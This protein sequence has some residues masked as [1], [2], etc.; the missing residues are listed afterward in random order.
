MERL[1]PMVLEEGERKVRKAEGVKLV[2]PLLSARGSLLLTDRR[3]LFNGESMWGELAYEASLDNI[4]GCDVKKPSFWSRG[5]GELSVTLQEVSFRA[6]VRDSLKLCST[7]DFRVDYQ[8]MFLGRREEVAK[9]WEAE[10]E[11]RGSVDDIP[12]YEM[13]DG[14]DEIFGDTMHR[15]V[16]CELAK[17]GIREFSPAVQPPVTRLVFVFE[18]VEQPEAFRSDVMERAEK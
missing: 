3:L 16:L 15:A 5:K 9:I 2:S 10:G 12:A 8:D 18:G 14:V 6:D 1:F 11:I 7:A 17:R 13:I 4:I